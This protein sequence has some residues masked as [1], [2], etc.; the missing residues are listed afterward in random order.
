[1]PD[2]SNPQHGELAKTG[3][4]DGEVLD[5][6]HGVRRD[7]KCVSLKYHII[8]LTL[9][10]ARAVRTPSHSRE[11][12]PRTRTA[13]RLVRFKRFLKILPSWIRGLVM[14]YP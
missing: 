8:T 7:S 10:R 6:V 5:S 1:M 3:Q 11:R 12:R 4:H 2:H 13:T 9:P 14:R